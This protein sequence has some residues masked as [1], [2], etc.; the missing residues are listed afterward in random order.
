MLSSVVELILFA[1]VER[2]CYEISM[3]AL[4]LHIILFL[5]YRN[6]VTL[7]V[8]VWIAPVLNAYM[9]SFM[10]SVYPFLYQR[11]LPPSFLLSAHPHSITMCIP[12][13]A[14]SFIYLFFSHTLY[15]FFAAISTCFIYWKRKYRRSLLFLLLQCS[16]QYT[17]LLF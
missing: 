6:V 2:L 3:S 9:C 17:E 1:Y 13:F 5:W 10:H 16:T 11:S 7:K 14:F 12:F 8:S 4:G 15:P